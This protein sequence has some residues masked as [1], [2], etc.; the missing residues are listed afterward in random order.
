MTG[1]IV[2]EP[3]QIYSKEKGANQTG[4]R[5]KA[6]CPIPEMANATMERWSGRLTKV[7]RCD[8]PAAENPMKRFR[9]AV[10]GFRRIVREVLPGHAGR[11]CQ[12][13]GEKQA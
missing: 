9:L 4:H 12:E 8:K 10:M 3:W 6:R 5:E 1:R 7:F 2:V 13:H 11:G